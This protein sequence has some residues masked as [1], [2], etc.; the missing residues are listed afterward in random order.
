[1]SLMSIRIGVDS[2]GTFT[3]FVWTQP[4]SAGV[5][6]RY[7]FK[8]HSTPDDPARAVLEGVERIVFSLVGAA[9][10]PPIAA[11]RSL[12][13]LSDSTVVGKKK[14]GQD[15][16]LQ[17]KTKSGRGQARPLH[18]DV[19][20][21]TTV[22]TN[23]LLTRSGARVVLLTSAGMEDVLEIGRQDRPLLYDLRPSL[24]PPL[25]PREL[26]LGVHERVGVSESERGAPEVLIALGQ[27]EAQRAARKVK[28]LKP[29]AVAICLLH[30]YMYPAHEALLA[31][32]L[33]EVLPADVPVF[34]SSEVDPQPR[35]Y[36][37]TSTTVIHAY[38][39]RRVDAYLRRLEAGLAGLAARAGIDCRLSVLSS[40]GG[41]LSAEQ[42]IAR[43]AELVLSGPAGGVRGAAEVMARAGAAELMARVVGAAE[44]RP[45]KTARISAGPTKTRQPTGSFIGL[46]MGG[47]S[48]DVCL[49]WQ[50]RVALD[51]GRL[52]EGLPLRSSRLAVHTIGAGGGSIARRG[53]G[54]ALLVGP[55]SAGADPG[56]AAYGRGQDVTVTDAALLAG[57]LPTGMRL[58]ADGAGSIRLDA[59]RSGRF[60]SALAKELKLSGEDCAEGILRIAEQH[61]AQAVRQVSQARGYDP[62]ACVLLP[63]GGAGGL[64]ACG[65]AQQLGITRILVPA[66][67][68]CL[69]ALG[70][71]LTS[72][73]Q[74]RI[75]SVMRVIDV[76]PAPQLRALLAPHKARLEADF[77]GQASGRIHWGCRALCRYSGQGHELAVD[78]MPEPGQKN[79]RVA[80]SFHTEHERQYGYSRPEAPVEV[81]SL[82]LSARAEETE[83]QGVWNLKAQWRY[84]AGGRALAIGKPVRGPLLLTEPTCTVFVA[85]GCKAQ[86][87]ELGNLF[88][89]L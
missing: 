28:A 31:A 59:R 58:G 26:R 55:Q 25:V 65:V 66:D 12:H 83:A 80:D 35:E 47:T 34:L 44:M 57:R 6:S 11:Q 82:V 67:A 56:P 46:D 29:E 42:A 73:Q 20:H 76:W 89:S 87:D 64:C 10:G 8:L 17:E 1:M 53:S 18:I 16:P 14:A 70:A 39:S 13:D 69:S 9:L 60:L 81:V 63:F 43:P 88:L 2:G 3:D 75:V 19:I 61:M 36:E 48:T 23:A 33:R 62:R 49:G 37:R 41:T 51:S 7:S 40:S 5:W 68:G 79:L 77:R 4:D 15:P 74:T 54:G 30:S 32:A 27:A 21:G 78:C 24:P 84:G 71:V 38:L 52:I 72:P 85:K 22:A 45:S 50:G 86:V